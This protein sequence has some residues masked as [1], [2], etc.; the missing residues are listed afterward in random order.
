MQLAIEDLNLDQKRSLLASLLNHNRPHRQLSITQERLW[1]LDQLQPGTPLYNFQTAIE[2]DGP[3]LPKALEIAAL[4]V[5]LRHEV[6]HIS[7]STEKGKPALSVMPPRTITITQHDLSALCERDQ[8]ARIETLGMEDVRNSF[9]LRRPP[10]LRLTL[11]RIAP[12]K[13]LLYLTMH[14]IVSDFLSLDVFLFEMGACYSALLEERR[15]TLPLL[16][17]GYQ[18][19]AERQRNMEA[20]DRQETH[21]AYWRRILSGATPIEWFS[22][23]VRPAQ[24]TGAAGTEFFIFPASLMQQIEVFARKHQITPFIVLLSGFNIL[25]Q[26]CSGHDDLIVGSPTAGRMRS[27]YESLIGMFSYPVLMRTSMAGNPNFLVLLQRIRKVALE[28]T[29]HSE[30]PLAKIID[31]VRLAG[32]QQGTLLRAMFS[33]VSH[34]RDL[35]FERLGCRRRACNR[36]L[37]DLDFFLTLYSDQGAW[38]GVLEYSADLFEPHTIRN[39]I[40]AYTAIL[41]TAIAEPTLSVTELAARVPVKPPMRVTVAATFTATP[42][43]EVLEFWARELDLQFVPIM[44]PYNQL[45][46]QLMDAH[47]PLLADGNTLNV[48]LVRPEDWI[49]YAR[50]DTCGK[51]CLMEQSTRDFIAAVCGAVPRMSC[52]L[53][54]YLCP[55]SPNLEAASS[56]MIATA[57]QSIRERLAGISM[58]EVIDAQSCV[59]KYSAGEIHD[60]QME[61]TAN[62]PYKPAFYA[63]LGTAITR[64]LRVQASRPRKVLVLDCDN[65]LW[66]GLCAEDGPQA[67]VI[68]L[69]HRALQRFVLEQAAAGVLICLNSKNEPEHVLAVLRE[70]TS[71]IV[72][73]ENITAFR[74]NWHP[75]SSNLQSL[76]AEL[77]LGL[78]SFV[79]L[80]DDARECA[81]VSARCPEILTLRLPETSAE[82]PRFLQNL[83]FFDRDHVSEEDRKRA[84]FYRDKQHRDLALRQSTSLAEFLAKLD[85]HVNLRPAASEQL[86]RIAQL[87]QRTNQFN[88]TG[89]VFNPLDLQQA[90]R[91]DLEVMAVEVSD[92]FG[93]Y[94]LVG[95]VM[96]RR[97][98]DALA[99]EAFYLSCRVLGRGVEHRI[100]AELGRIAQASGLLQLHINYNQSSRNQ[101]F[102]HFLDRLPGRL[103]TPARGPEMFILT[104]ADAAQAVL[105]PEEGVSAIPS[106]PQVV[107]R[108]DVPPR[109]MARLARLPHE[110]STAA[111]IMA[112]LDAAASGRREGRVAAAFAAP[113]AGIENTIAA[114]WRTILRLDQVGRNDNFFE[115][116]GNSLLIVQ[117]NSNLISKLG[118][119]ISIAEMFQY[120][121]VASLA[122]HIGGQPSPDQAS[123]GQ[124]LETTARSLR[125]RA[126]LQERRRQFV[127]R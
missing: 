90:V 10:L 78:D 97:Q 126:F 62:I 107:S 98:S 19:F 65:T 104:A 80:D 119:D 47:G 112:R 11:V 113:R 1:Q 75:K 110:L 111:Q 16:T 42:L 27:E 20:S 85:L 32:P 18:D 79:F 8:A 3:L 56:S 29:E 46:Q 37:T 45:L 122:G 44:A 40:V 82:F 71:M 77:Q 105:V 64:Q 60:P 96:Y 36:G 114:E 81:E 35:R 108:T 2:L 66:Q 106:E 9:D 68:T 92:R 120:P 101:P 15:A 57:E 25:L 76:A 123:P 58:V 125:T 41:Q 55:A 22:D 74:I 69:G 33:Y 28:A 14:H 88:S 49:R 94:G 13:H 61:R 84:G 31:A 51:Q 95:A 89:L 67:V 34:L 99:V 115:L 50:P 38:Q 70:N 12:E 127:A 124:S 52:P 17:V 26:G 21:L 48:L 6:L 91:Q 59:E 73:E 86:V 53:K 39:L 100:L 87:S 24:A 103:E 118:P 102:R 109:G 93:E 5:V 4:Q 54:I 43:T 117:L 83:W 30:V 121:T 7:Y 72:R 23:H 63:A 116:G